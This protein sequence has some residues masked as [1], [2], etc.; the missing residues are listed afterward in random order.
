MAKLVAMRINLRLGPP[1]EELRQRVAVSGRLR[2]AA[3]GISL[4]S[5]LRSEEPE[6]ALQEK[7]SWLTCHNPGTL[8]SVRHSVPDS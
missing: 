4:A 7:Q 1:H 8:E 6:S 3:L 2:T 5:G